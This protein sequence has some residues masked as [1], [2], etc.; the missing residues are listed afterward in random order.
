MILKKRGFLRIIVDLQ[1]FKVVQILERHSD[2]AA[3]KKNHF[4]N[5]FPKNNLYSPDGFSPLDARFFA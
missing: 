4:S 5:F 3:T 1:A 2:A